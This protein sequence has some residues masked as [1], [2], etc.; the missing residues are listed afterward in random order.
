M[1][2]ADFLLTRGWFDF[3]EDIYPIFREISDEDFW[4]LHYNRAKYG[5]LVQMAFANC[6]TYPKPR[7]KI[8]LNIIEEEKDETEADI[9]GPWAQH[10]KNIQEEAPEYEKEEF[11]QEFETEIN[12]IQSVLD[13]YR[14]NK[15]RH[16]KQIVNDYISSLKDLKI[17]KN[18]LV[19]EK[20]TQYDRW[21]EK[22]YSKFKTNFLN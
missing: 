2:D 8:T 10:L 5:H 1:E 22:E 14:S 19:L 4:K 6:V 13:N 12:S 7:G 18:K 9:S 17:Q 21:V 20:K 16:D 11:I 15:N 3:V